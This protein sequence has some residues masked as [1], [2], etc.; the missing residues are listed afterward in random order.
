[1][2]LLR[3]TFASGSVSL[4]IEANVTE[5]SNS[6]E[7]NIDSVSVTAYDR[8]TGTEIDMSDLWEQSPFLEIVDSINW[9]EIWAS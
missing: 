5:P 3:K 6:S 9:R 8:S 2:P 7:L 4:T 1:M